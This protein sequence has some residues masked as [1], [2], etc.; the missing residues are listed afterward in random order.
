[1]SIAMCSA[2]RSS[3]KPATR[4]L[5][6]LFRGPSARRGQRRPASD[7]LLR[8]VH[9]NALCDAHPLF[10]ALLR[11]RMALFTPR[12]GKPADPH[13]LRRQS[14]MDFG[15]FRRRARRPSKVACQSLL[16][17]ALIYQPARRVKAIGRSG[18]HGRSVASGRPDEGG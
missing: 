9:A 14:C 6:D 18:W 10:T 16:A 11:R 1:M 15:A 8:L 5:A 17:N 3:G 12:P 2:E 13:R 4:R 7:D